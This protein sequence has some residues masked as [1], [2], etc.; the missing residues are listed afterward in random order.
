[1]RFN[2][3]YHKLLTG[4]NWESTPELRPWS[5]YSGKQTR[6]KVVSG[7]PRRQLWGLTQ[8]LAF[9]FAEE[10]RPNYCDFLRN[11][12][13]I[14][15]T[16]IPKKH[17]CSL[18]ALWGSLTKST[19]ICIRCEKVKTHWNHSASTSP[20]F[21]MLT[22]ENT[23]TPHNDRPSNRQRI[24]LVQ[25]LQRSYYCNISTRASNKEKQ[26]PSRLAW[27]R[28]ATRQVEF[29]GCFWM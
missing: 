21:W 24:Q 13:K 23:R 28:K 18:S 19:G 5:T 11:I 10:H 20:S 6:P 3:F 15:N 22:S 12:Q 14:T 16:R 17:T 8:L 25:L 2:K 26:I 4:W 9:P 27:S 1:M 29:S 7:K